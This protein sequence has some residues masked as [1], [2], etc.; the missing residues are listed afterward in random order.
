MI[1]KTPKPFGFGVDL[2]SDEYNFNRMQDFNLNA[3]LSRVLLQFVPFMFALCFHEYAHGWMAKRKGDNTAEIMGRLTLNPMAHADLIGTIV[4]P[5]MSIFFSFPFFGWAK[6]VPVNERNLKFPRQDMFWIALAGPLS[7]LLLAFLATLGMVFLPRLGVT[8][9]GAAEMLKVFLVINLFLAVF[10]LIPFH[11]LDGAKVIARFL[12]VRANLAL[13]NSQQ[14]TNMI[15]IVLMF[16]GAFRYLA[17]PVYFMA[18]GL[19]SVAYHL[20]SLIA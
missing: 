20:S 19:L 1:Q 7:N 8:S 12:P 14:M 18:E 11:P 16:S 13:E 6:P 10:N 5:I 4:L 15:L 2:K 17:V 3:N 9:E